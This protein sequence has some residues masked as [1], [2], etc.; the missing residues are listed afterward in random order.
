VSVDSPWNPCSQSWRR[1]QR[2]Q[3]EGFAEK[4]GFKPAVKEWRNTGNNKYESSITTVKC[5]AQLPPTPVTRWDQCRPNANPT[6]RILICVIMCLT[7]AF[8]YRS[9]HNTI[10]D[11][12]LRSD[13]NTTWVVWLYFNGAWLRQQIWTILRPKPSRWRDSFE[14]S[15]N[16]YLDLKFK[17][18]TWLAQKLQQICY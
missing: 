15:W 10:K 2:L 7:I 13:Q 18:L 6:V 4:E 1:E 12:I 8:N 14:C 9:L 16:L 3:W 11:A 17:R 5:F